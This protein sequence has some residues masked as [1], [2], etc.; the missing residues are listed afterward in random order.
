MRSHVLLLFFILNFSWQLCFSQSEVIK[1]RGRVVDSEMAQPVPFASIVIRNSNFGTASDSLGNFIIAFESTRH[2]DAFIRI[3]SIGFTSQQFSIDSILLLS[4][5]SVVTFRLKP[6]IISLEQVNISE[7]AI[8]GKDIIKLAIANITANAYPKPL[9]LEYYSNIKVSDSLRTLYTLENVFQ[10]FNENG[11]HTAF[12]LQQR[13]TGTS[14]FPKSKCGLPANFDILQMDILTSPYR[15]GIF[16]I[17]NL[18]QFDV[19]YQGIIM[20]EGD[21]VYVIEYNA[22]KPTKQITGTGNVPRNYFYSGKLY[23]DISS[24][25][26]VRHSLQQGISKQPLSQEILYRKIDGFYLP[27]YIESS[28]MA[29]VEKRKMVKLTNVLMLRDAQLNSKRPMPSFDN[30]N[31]P[32]WDSKFWSNFQ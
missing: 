7:S 31:P 8:N 3:S 32:K 27:Y 12:Y 11:Y 14:P 15:N 10:D 19:K 5:E 21:S 26:I 18:S 4:K 30:C 9:T 22:P 29:E 28:R 17:K 24:N 25:A 13:F 23:I 6:D 2:P 20:Y 16:D 1:I